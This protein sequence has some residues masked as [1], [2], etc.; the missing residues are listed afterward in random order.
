[1]AKNDKRNQEVQEDEGR[2]DDQEK[3]VTPKQDTN[4]VRESGVV[5]TG[6]MQ[7]DRNQRR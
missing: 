1:M 2:T 3:T 5:K 7:E 4:N 6:R